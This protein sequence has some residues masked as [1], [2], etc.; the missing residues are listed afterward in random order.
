[1]EQSNTAK[2]LQSAIKQ[3]LTVSFNVVRKRCEA[4]THSRRDDKLNNR[5]SAQRSGSP[6]NR[7]SGH[8]YMKRNNL[9]FQ[10]I[11]YTTSA[12]RDSSNSDHVNTAMN[13][14]H[15]LSLLQCLMTCKA[16]QEHCAARKRLAI[17]YL[18]SNGYNYA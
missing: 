18:D 16:K 2:Q 14:Q 9:M 6:N 1:M 10:V 12:R 15:R 13:V 5:N 4:Y 11:H 3:N 17:K 8:F 7:C